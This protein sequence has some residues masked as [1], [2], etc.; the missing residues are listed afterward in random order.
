ML[1]RPGARVFVWAIARMLILSTHNRHD[2]DMQVEIL[3]SSHL[4]SF[5]KAYYYYFG[6]YMVVERHK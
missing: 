6:L 3:V 5:L 2:Q 4:S 1:T